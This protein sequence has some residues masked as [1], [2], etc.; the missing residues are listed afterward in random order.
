MIELDQIF[1]EWTSCTLKDLNLLE[2]QPNRQVT[3]NS[4]AHMPT[5]S[6]DPTL[7]TTLHTNWWQHHQKKRFHQ[8]NT[9][10]CPINYQQL[11]LVVGFKCKKH[12]TNYVL[13]LENSIHIMKLNKRLSGS[14]QGYT[15]QDP[16]PWKLS[17]RCVDIRV[18]L[19]V[20]LFSPCLWAS[21]HPLLSEVFKVRK[22]Y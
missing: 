12:T 1:K 7:A 22:F 8:D 10:E 6:L 4:E 13:V 17:P 9:Q 20:I 14:K 19:K 2:S 11:L 18:F 16:C 21:F 15:L 5:Q 3:L